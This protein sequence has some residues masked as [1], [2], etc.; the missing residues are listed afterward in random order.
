MHRH[1]PFFLF[2][3]F[4][5]QNLTPVKLITVSH[6]TSQTNSEVCRKQGGG[7]GNVVKLGDDCRLHYHGGCKISWVTFVSLENVMLL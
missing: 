7:R 6:D 4:K 5:I 1:L 2:F 3:P